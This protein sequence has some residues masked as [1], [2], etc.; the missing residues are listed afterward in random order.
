[1]PSY[2]ITISNG[3]L[4]SKAKEARIRFNAHSNDTSNIA[5]ITGGTLVG[6]FF[7]KKRYSTSKLNQLE[8]TLVPLVNAEKEEPIA[9]EQISI[10]VNQSEVKSNVLCDSEL[11]EA[12]SS[13]QIKD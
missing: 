4:T 9:N 7:Y 10:L 2:K 3:I 12:S 13:L 11:N 1:M 5:A 6:L 8:R